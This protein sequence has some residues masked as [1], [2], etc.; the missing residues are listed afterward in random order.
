MTE[1]HQEWT[2]LLSEYLDGGLSQDERRDV[3]AHLEGCPRCR[4]V[5]EELEEVVRRAHGLD[6]ML[7][8]RDLWPGI[9]GAIGATPGTEGDPVRHLASV[10]PRSPSE[11]GARRGRAG[12][13][14]SVPQLAAAAIVLMVCSA[15]VTWWAGADRGANRTEAGRSAAPLFEPSP[16]STDLS[17]VPADVA[18]QLAELQDTLA[19]ARG[20]L[21]P[22]TERIIRKNLA[23]IDRAIA[24]SRAA[25]AADPGDP[26]LEEHL[27]RTYQRKVTYLREAA[28]IVRGVSAP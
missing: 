21:D 14:L 18:K 13:W 28:R 9:E 26:F 5:L 23:V 12:V 11:D 27:D 22:T 19:A 15:S 16:A 10:G 7:P 3:E 8:G 4:S 25:L 6:P 2:D 1:I 20:R 17:G 24:E